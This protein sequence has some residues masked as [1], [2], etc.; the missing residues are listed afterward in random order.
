VHV[1]HD[2]PS[3]RHEN[4]AT[5]FAEN[6][7]IADVLAVVPL[8]PESIVVSGGVVS[9]ATKVHVLTAGVASTFPAASTAATSK[10]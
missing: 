10:R 2:D 9:P 6:M 4:E 8:G 5:S 3:S 1:P 7:R